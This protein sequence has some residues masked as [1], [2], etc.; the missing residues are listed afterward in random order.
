MAWI[1]Q[2]RPFHRSASVTNVPARSVWAPT[3]VHAC[4]DTHDT[5]LNPVV[6][7]RR[8]PAGGWGVDWIA[9]LVPPQR[10]PTVAGAP[11]PLVESPTAVHAPAVTHDTP[12]RSTLSRSPAGSGMDWIAQL[13][14]SHRSANVTSGPPLFSSTP[15][16]LFSSTPTAVH[17]PDD[18]HEAPNSWLVRWLVCAPAAGLGAAW[19]VPLVPSQHPAP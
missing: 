4:A 5:P 16:P 14:P 2:R 3:A 17:A 19:I 6:G 10:S 12:V 1:V 18:T 7:L 15:T 13:V 9:Q 8:A 11:P